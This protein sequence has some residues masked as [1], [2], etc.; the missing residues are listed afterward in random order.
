MPEQFLQNT[1]FDLLAISFSS[2]DTSSFQCVTAEVEGATS[3]V[4][5]SGHCCGL[6][7]PLPA[8]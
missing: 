4:L 5:R 6:A 2:C 7:F 3:L 8:T 1:Q